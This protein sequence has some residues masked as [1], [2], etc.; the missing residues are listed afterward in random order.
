VVPF[1]PG[2]ATDLI[3]RIIAKN[4]GEVLGQQ[5]VVENRGGAG[6]NIGAEAVAKAPADGYTLLLAAMTFSLNH[7]NFRKRKVTLRSS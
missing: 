6:G 1:P 2:G 4:L 5:V 7:G 3:G